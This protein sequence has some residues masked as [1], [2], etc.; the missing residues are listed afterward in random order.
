MS[1]PGRPPPGVISYEGSDERIV[2]AGPGLAAVFARTLDRWTHLVRLAGGRA[3]DVAQVVESDSERD[4]ATR[5]V[6]PVY[7]EIHH[8]ELAG[9]PAQCLLAT[10][11][12]FQH[13]FS[14]A[15]SLRFDPD[16]AGSLVVDFDIADR[17]RAPVESLAATYLVKLDGGALANADPTMIAW[18]VSGELDGRLE[19]LVDPPATLALAEAGRQAARVQVLAALDARNFTHRFHYRW[20]WMSVSGM[21]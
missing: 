11:R 4:W 19:L 15:V 14:A 9:R 13:H 5:V 17:C 3:I 20:R 18:N 1:G 12:S 8:H 10:G 2:I 6:S 7:Q 21:T 16:R